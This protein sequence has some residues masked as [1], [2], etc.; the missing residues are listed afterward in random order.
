MVERISEAPSPKSSNDRSVKA[1]VWKASGESGVS[2]PLLVFFLRGIPK[3]L[4]LPLPSELL[5]PVDFLDD[6]PLNFNLGTVMGC[7][8][9]CARD[10]PP[11]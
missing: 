5:D 11:G 10:R 1:G 7:I 4:D 3:K 8:F 6:L 2:D 9:G